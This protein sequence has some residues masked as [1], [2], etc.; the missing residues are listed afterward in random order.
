MTTTHDHDYDH[1]GYTDADIPEHV[2]AIL[3][4]TGARIDAPLDTGYTIN[5]TTARAL[6]DTPDDPAAE[7]LGP[8]IQ[9]GGRTIIVGDTGEGKTTIAL[10]M[11]KATLTGADFLGYQ[12]IGGGRALVADLEQGVRSVNRALRDAGLS[13][14]QDVD[15]ALIPD[16]L[17]LDRSTEHLLELDRIITLGGYT[18][19]ILDPYYKAH[20]AEDPNAERPIIDLMRILDGLRAKHGFALL[21]PTHPRKRSTIDGTGPRRLTIH[22]PAGSGAITRGAEIVIGIERVAHG[23][24][25]LRY[26]KDRD[27]DLPVGE[28]WHLLYNRRDG[29]TRDPKD[30]QP[31]RDYP[32]EI[33]ATEDDR[34]LTMKE[35]KDLISASHDR[36][37]EAVETLLER[38]DM[39][40]IVGPPG[41]SHRA[42]C[43]KLATEEDYPH[44]L[45]P[46]VPY[47]PHDERTVG[48]S[49][50]PDPPGQSRTVQDSTLPLGDETPTVPLS[51]PIREDSGR[52]VV[53]HPGLLSPG[54]EDSQ[55]VNEAL[56]EDGIPF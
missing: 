11:A 6:C 39:I 26:L 32:E 55:P 17:A 8:L 45:S 23:Y 7:L 10:Q 41:R 51:S 12:G 5:V 14:R 34:W 30:L 4:M 27:S 36:T 48:K 28:A 18:I 40:Q 43:Y 56:P 25:R 2:H 44:L 47:C 49:T 9:K 21:L 20:Q 16:G 19:V 13:N 37:R 1:P 24:A 15:L 29:Y 35:W 31:D 38:G 46:T 42:K 33:K 3:Q 50:V 22:D 52:T 53:S 54:V